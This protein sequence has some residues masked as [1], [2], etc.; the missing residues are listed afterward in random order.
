MPAGG[1]IM[2]PKAMS[3]AQ[4]ALQLVQFQNA[5]LK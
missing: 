2:A 5:A 4:L 3:R 1:M